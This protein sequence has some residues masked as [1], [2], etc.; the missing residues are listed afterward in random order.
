VRG[1]PAHVAR[2][3]GG[4]GAGAIHVRALPTG[5]RIDG[6]AILSPMHT[7]GLLGPAR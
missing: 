7:T 6:G 2:A 4:G 3:G 1:A 5:Y